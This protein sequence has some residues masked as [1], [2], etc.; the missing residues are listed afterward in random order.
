MK[1]LPF[2]FF[3]VYSHCELSRQSSFLPNGFLRI[4][5]AESPKSTFAMG[6][7][8]KRISYLKGKTKNYEK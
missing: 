2:G 4:E 7:K 1:A 6:R 3:M 5:F 8:E